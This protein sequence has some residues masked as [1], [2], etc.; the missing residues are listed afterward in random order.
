[1]QSALN[2]EKNV[3]QSLLELHH[4]ASSHDDAQMCDFL[5]KEYLE[6]Q[7]K[8][9]KELSNHITNLRRVGP[10]LGEFMFDKETFDSS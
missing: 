8:D 7:V 10:G 3:N 6:E 4:V 9:I 5:E 2:L 1:M